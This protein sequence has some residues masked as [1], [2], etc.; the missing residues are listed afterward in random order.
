M[1]NKEERVNGGGGGGEL[2]N[3]LPL[4]KKGGRLIREGGLNREFTVYYM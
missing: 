3:F 2:N 1:K 4:K